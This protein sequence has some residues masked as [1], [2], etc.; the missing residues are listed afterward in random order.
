ME[1]TVPEL[2]AEGVKLMVVGMTIV[3]SF[4]LLL[5]GMLFGMSRL[6]SPLSPDQGVRAGSPTE[7]APGLEVEVDARLAA[8]IVA[9][10]SYYRRARQS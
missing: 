7:G 1:P 6:A 8:A 9:A 5:V 4:L 10:V 3:F 2:L